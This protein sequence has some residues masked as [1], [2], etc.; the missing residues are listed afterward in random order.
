MEGSVSSSA[1]QPPGESPWKIAAQP[2]KIIRNCYQY[3]QRLENLLN[4]DPLVIK[5]INITYTNRILRDSQ[6]RTPSVV[7]AAITHFKSLIQSANEATAGIAAIP[8]SRI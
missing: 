1:S 7:E 5:R 2:N 6:G 4:A 3:V 8:A